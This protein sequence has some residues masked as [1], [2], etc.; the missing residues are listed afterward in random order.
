MSDE[1]CGRCGGDL[2]THSAH[3][4]LICYICQRELSS[5]FR[6]TEYKAVSAEKYAA[7]ER[8]L[9]AKTADRN[10]MADAVRDLSHQLTAKD[11]QI[12]GLKADWKEISD[13]NDNCHQ[14]AANYELL[15]DKLKGVPTN[16]GDCP[17]AKKLDAQD[18]EIARLRLVESTLEKV[19]DALTPYLAEHAA[20]NISTTT[21]VP[22]M[23]KELARLCRIEAAI[24][25]NNVAKAVLDPMLLTEKPTTA[26]HCYRDA[27]LAAAE[28]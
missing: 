7:L 16:H 6:M 21:A 17:V 1:K 24:K 15:L 10:T 9:A 25:D 26:I 18:A 27:V 12:E 8:Q 14:P 22:H 11:I 19:N 3:E 23:L 2:G 28:K 13:Q 4:P 20:D 5:K